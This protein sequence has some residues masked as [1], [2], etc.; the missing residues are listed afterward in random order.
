MVFTQLAAVAMQSP[1]LSQNSSGREIDMG[2]K[3][4]HWAAI[5]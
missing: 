4:A 5:S 2:V 3:I 1:V